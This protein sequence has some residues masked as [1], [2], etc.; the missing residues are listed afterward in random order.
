M[1]SAR[2][3]NPSRPDTGRREKSKLKVIFSHFFVVPQKVLREDFT[4]PF[5][6][7]QRS[8]KIKIY[9]KFYFNNFLKCTARRKGLR[10]NIFTSVNVPLSPTW[11]WVHSLTIA[12][13]KHFASKK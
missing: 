10:R 12:D 7:P 11:S 2:D 8:V 9:V 5:E 3:V 1:E 4:K 13:L 6:A